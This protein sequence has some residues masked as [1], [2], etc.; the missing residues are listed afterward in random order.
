MK[1]YQPT[2]WNHKGNQES[3]YRILYDQLVPHEGKA[4]TT[5]GEILRMVSNIYYD[6]YNNGGCN[7]ISGGRSYDVSGLIYLVP[8]EKKQE[9]IIFGTPFDLDDEARMKQADNFVDWAIAYVAAIAP[10]TKPA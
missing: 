1:T 5:A 9:A 3:L 6:H 2:Y 8:D 10:V 7:L 4:N